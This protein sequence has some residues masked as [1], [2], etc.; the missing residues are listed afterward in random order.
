MSWCGGGETSPTPGVLLRHS[1]MWGSTFQPGSS[2]PSPGLA[3]WAILI[4]I[5]L[6][7]VRYS[8]VTPNRPDA[9]CLMAELAECPSAISRKRRGSSPPSP[10]FDLPPSLFIAMASVACASI[11]M[12][13]YDMAPVLNRFTM[14]AADS[15]S[16]ILSAFLSYS[17]GLRNS[18]CPHRDP[19][20]LVLLWIAANWAYAAR[21]FV[22]AASWSFAMAMGSFR[23]S[24]ESPSCRR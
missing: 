16:S 4:W 9:T 12:E 15:T 10:V 11:E 8:I 2:P 5:S 21:E 20:V 14:L 13:P 1:A 24:S 17:S 7:F 22:R 3:P 18:S 23:C 6:A 19:F